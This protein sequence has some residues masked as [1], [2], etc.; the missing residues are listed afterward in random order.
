MLIVWLSQA[1]FGTAALA[2]CAL[3]CRAVL[4]RDARAHLWLTIAGSVSLIFFVSVPRIPP[5]MVAI[6]VVAILA[7]ILMAPAPEAPVSFDSTATRK[8]RRF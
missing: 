4:R 5:Q 3:T 1:L 7:G 6:A 2:F 8:S